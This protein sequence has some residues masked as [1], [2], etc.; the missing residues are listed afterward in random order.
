ML[1]HFF[2]PVN[3]LDASRDASTM[4]PF[5]TAGL[6]HFSPPL[7]PS[8]YSDRALYGEDKKESPIIL[9][10]PLNLAGQ[11]SQTVWWEASYFLDHSPLRRLDDCLDTLLHFIRL[12]DVHYEENIVT[13][14]GC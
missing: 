5:Q 11:K 9:P 1:R 10:K 4:S 6:C 14:A 13:G 7:S 12:K 8:S 2:P 3:L